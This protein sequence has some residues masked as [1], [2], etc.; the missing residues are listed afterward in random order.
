VAEEKPIRLITPWIATDEPV[1]EKRGERAYFQF[2]EYA[3]TFARIIA[4][5]RTHTPLTIGIHGGW[6]TGKTTLMHAIEEQLCGWRRE[7]LERPLFLNPGEVNI[8]EDESPYRPCRTVWFNAWK[9]SRQEALLV[10]L[11]ETILNQMRRDGFIH[12]LY[13]ELARPDQ[14]RMKVA[15]AVISTLSQ[16]FTLGQIEIDL[17]KFQTESRFK[18]HMAFLDEFQEVFDRLLRWYVVRDWKDERE[19]DDQKGVL[20]IFVDDLDRCLPDKT[21]QVL[22]TIKLM[23]GKPGTIFVLGASRHVVQAA[24]KAHYKLQ[25]FENVDPQDYLDKIVQLRFDLP[26]VRRG[27][28]SKFISESPEWKWEE[29]DP[30]LVNLPLVSEGVPTNPRRVKTFINYLELHWGLLANSGQVTSEDREQFVV[31]MVLTDVAPELV[32]HLRGMRTDRWKFILASLHA[33]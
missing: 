31:W 19:V 26:P 9:Y 29:D 3:K 20:V 12:E 11:I 10:A 8:G 17:T 1:E 14:P 13:A 23:M 24:V 33:P 16:V 7:G 28:M 21:V 4:A 6:G 27:A 22:E 15:E 2:E 25:E 32:D 30:L 18:T 5:K